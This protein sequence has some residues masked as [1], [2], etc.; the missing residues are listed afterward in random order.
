MT[1][2]G[3]PEALAELGAKLSAEGARRWQIPGADVAGH[4]PQVDPFEKELLEELAPIR[5]RPLTVPFYSTVRGGLLETDGLDAAYW[6]QNIRRPVE[7]EHTVRSLLDAG[8]R[9]LIEVSPHPVLTNSVRENAEDAGAEVVVVDTLRRGAGGWDRFLLSMAQA[10]V[11]GVSPDWRAV[12]DGS[13]GERVDLPTY[14]FQRRRHWIEPPARRAPDGDAS[15]W[16]AVDRADLPVLS[17]ALGL[18]APALDAVVPAL[19]SWRERQQEGSVVDSW[20]Y[21]VTWRPSAEATAPRLS[22]TWPLVIPQGYEEDPLT[23]LAERALTAHGAAPVRIV[24]DAAAAERGGV[25]P[26]GVQAAGVLSLLALDQR[27]HGP[28]PGVSA[29]LAATAVLVQEL[30][31]T[32]VSAPLW[33]V[34]SGAVSTGGPDGPAAPAQ[35]QIWG[36]GRVVGLEHRDRWGGLIDVVAPVTEESGR[37]LAHALG[38]HEDQVAVRSVGTFVR[39]LT[40]APL[41]GRE[42]ASPWRPRGI[43]LITGGT[44]A[45]GAHVARRLAADGAQH[46]VLT[47]RRGPGAAGAD[48]L[49]AELEALGARVTVA[50]CDVADR[51]AV[52]ELVSGLTA[53]GSVVRT[54]VHAAGVGEWSPLSGTA[55]GTW[56]DVIATKVAGA[57]NLAELVDPEGLDAFVLFSSISATWGS[58]N[59]AGYSAANSFLD[60]WAEQL[61]AGGV[62]ATSVAWGAWAGEG[63]ADEGSF[64]EHFRR[65]GL[66]EMAPE[67][68]LTA[69]WQAVEHQETCLTV[70]NMDWSLF[71]PG[72]TMARPRPLIED[73]PEVKLALDADEAADGDE[74]SLR[75]ELAEGQ[76]P[77]ADPASDDIDSMDADELVEMVLRAAD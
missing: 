66:L 5:P 44:G 58:G 46:V 59:Q 6:Y 26:D 64:E 41:A 70:S 8:H 9:T 36:L 12:H 73:V 57:V 17:R 50:A 43:A 35:A 34:T 62:P 31:D 56:S 33:C 10:H 75:T 60:A 2:S 28:V 63:M 29:G 65:R 24:V 3:D 48:G 52:A 68:A 11:H 72:F 47:S 67:S 42:P 19:R 18:D 25:L 22:G 40:R 74:R 15:F 20:R 76:S 45:L 1:V 49:R 37:R 71:V 4:S 7:F 23:L 55:L 32:K 16:T 51:A 27:P 69:L 77:A 38:G 14:G 30:G 39:R 21:R 61:R 53:D 54:V 13:G